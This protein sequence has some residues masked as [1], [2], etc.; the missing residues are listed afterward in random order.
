MAR[1]SGFGSRGF[2]E[3]QR[4]GRAVSGGGSFGQSR[5]RSGAERDVERAT[6]AAAERRATRERAAAAKK[7]GT[8]QFGQRGYARTAGQY[9]GDPSRGYVDPETGRPT[10][11]LTMK[12]EAEQR[13]WPSTLAAHLMGVVPGMDVEAREF[14][15]QPEMPSGPAP[16]AT[17]FGAGRLVGDIVGMGLGIPGLGELGQQGYEAMGGGQAEDINMGLASLLSEG[18]PVTAA[19]PSGM[20]GRDNGD[21]AFLPMP[22][23]AQAPIAAAPEPTEADRLALAA[24]LMGMPGYTS[25]GQGIITG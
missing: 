6:R 15:G 16:S 13:G 11:S 1:T 12:E 22:Q 25:S 8:P 19:A 5:D 18:G 9:A 10:R 17:T 24:A 23:V 4:K 3:R 20:L 7:A 2:S 14:V 21:S